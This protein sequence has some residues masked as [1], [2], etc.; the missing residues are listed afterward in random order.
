MILLTGNYTFFNL[1]TIV[2][3]ICLLDDKCILSRIEC[4][5]CKKCLCCKCFRKG[6]RNGRFRCWVNCIGCCTTFH[7]AEVINGN[8]FESPLFLVENLISDYCLTNVKISY[9]T[10]QSA[11]HL[12]I[13]AYQPTD[14]PTDRPTD[15]PTNPL[16]LSPIVS[17]I[18]LVPCLLPNHQL[19]S[20]PLTQPPH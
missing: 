19:T 6:D 15:R 8:V 7:K 17:W 1:L 4:L 2:L 12:H 5:L 16:T 18:V 20:H 13:P 3:C 10:S 9:Q 11:S 14:Q